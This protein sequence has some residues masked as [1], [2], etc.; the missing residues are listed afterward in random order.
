MRIAAAGCFAG[1]GH[2]VYESSAQLGSALAGEPAHGADRDPEDRPGARAQYDRDPGREP[3]D[4]P[5]A[6]RREDR[7]ARAVE[8]APGRALMDGR[9]HLFQVL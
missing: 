6:E 2:H 1:D 5:G 7:T 9:A 8:G 4:G 3:D